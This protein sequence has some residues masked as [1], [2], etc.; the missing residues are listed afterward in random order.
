MCEKRGCKAENG[1]EAVSAVPLQKCAPQ[2]AAPTTSITF[3]NV[4]VSGNIRHI[5]RDPDAIFGFNLRKRRGTIPE[6]KYKGQNFS[7]SSN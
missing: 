3:R 6:L 2:Q 5:V 4:E 7:C 1:A